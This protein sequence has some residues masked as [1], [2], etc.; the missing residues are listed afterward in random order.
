MVAGIM[1][2][3]SFDELLPL[4]EAYGEHHKTIYGFIAG[5]LIMAITL[6]F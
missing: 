3:I 4:A 6:I 2:F 5:M 1:V